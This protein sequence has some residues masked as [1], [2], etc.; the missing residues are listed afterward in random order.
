MRSIT[1]SVG[2][3]ALALAGVGFAPSIAEACSC[4]RAKSATIAAANASAV[5]EGEVTAFEAGEEFKVATVKVLRTWKGMAA[6][7]TEITVQ[8]RLN[9]AACGREF[10]LDTYLFYARAEDTDQSRYADGLCSR[11]KLSSAAADDFAELG[12]ANGNWTAPEGSGD[13]DDGAAETPEEPPSEPAINPFE[14]TA[15]DNPNPTAASSA[16]GAPAE[17]TAAEPTARGCSI[18][19][20]GGAPAPAALW[21]AIPLLAARRGRRRA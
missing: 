11:T 16:N 15:Q 17:P 13:P 3:F 7:G 19:G 6:A 21:L 14:R 18:G 12:E 9:G 8:T 10:A 1:P 5:F 2:I 20:D 4:V